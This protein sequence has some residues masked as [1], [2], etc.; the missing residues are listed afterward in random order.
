MMD[1]RGA[2][3]F[4]QIAIHLGDFVGAPPLMS[5]IRAFSLAALSG[6]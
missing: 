1:T 6:S 4:N 3:N 2:A 5:A